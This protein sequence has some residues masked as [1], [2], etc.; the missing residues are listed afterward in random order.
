MNKTCIVCQC[1][2]LPTVE[3]PGVKRPRHSEASRLEEKGSTH[4]ILAGHGERGSA[5]EASGGRAAS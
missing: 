3:R 1:N 2:S 5:G 4:I